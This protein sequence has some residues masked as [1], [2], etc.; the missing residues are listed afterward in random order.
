MKKLTLLI[1][2]ALFFLSSIQAQISKGSVW[3]GGNIGFSNSKNETGESFKNNY[4]SISP[5]IGVAIKE[6]LILGLQFNYDRSVFKTEFNDQTIEHYGVDLFERK[7]WTIVKRF[8]AFGQFDLGYT[9]EKQK[10]IYGTSKEEINGWALSLGAGPGLSFELSRRFQLETLLSDLF[11]LSYGKSKRTNTDPNGIV[12][13]TKRQSS[14]GGVNFDNA[15]N[16]TIGIRFLLK[17][18]GV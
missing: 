3:L 11:Y 16:L 14:S 2:I 1:A 7:Y 4:Y 6:N 12:S 17:K 5:A 15:S 8:Y 9:K 13:E 10:S 18:Q